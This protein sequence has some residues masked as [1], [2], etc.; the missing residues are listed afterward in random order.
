MKTIT[1]IP[2]LIAVTAYI[3]GTALSLHA[4]ASGNARKAASLPAT[5]ATAPIMVEVTNPA[6]ATIHVTYS[7]PEADVQ[8][9]GRQF[10]GTALSTIT[11]GNALQSSNEGEPV[12]PVVP[13]KIVLPAGCSIDAIKVTG[14]RKKTMEGTYRIRHGEAKIPL[15]PDAKPR[16]A[17][18]KSSIYDSDTPFPYNVVELVGVQKKRGV[19]IAILKI[20]PVQYRPRSGK[21]TVYESISFSLQTKKG[22]ANSRLKPRPNTFN[23]ASMH[24]EN[25][26]ALDTYGGEDESESSVPSDSGSVVPLGICDPAD[27]YR[28]VVVTA[29]SIRTATTDYTINDL[30]AHKQARGLTATIVTIEDVLANYTGTDNAERLRNF[31]IDAYTNWETDFVLLGG[32]IN[33]IPMRALHCTASSYTDEI[34]SD[35]YYQCLDGTYNSDGDSYWGEPTDGPGGTD[36]DLMAEVYIGRA[37]AENCLEMSNF[38]YKTLSYENASASAPYLRNALMVGEY[39]GFGGVADYATASM[40]EIRLGSSE[41]GYTTAGFA[42][43]PLFTVDT[44]YDRSGYEW[45]ASEIISRM[46]S[47]VYGIYNHLGHANAT[48]VMKFYNADADALTNDNFFF[49]Y[50]QGCIPGNFEV[51]CIAEHLTTSNRHGAFAVVFNARYGWGANSSTDGPSQRFDR[52]FWDAYFSEFMSNFGALNADSHE[53]NIWDINGDCIRWCFYETN[54]LGDPQTPVRG[55]V[56][57][58]SLAYHSHTLNDASGGNGDGLINPGETVALTLTAANLGTESATGVTA[59]ISTSDPYISVTGVTCIFGTIQCCGAT[60]VADGPVTLTVQSDCPTPHTATVSCE[61]RDSRD[62]TWTSTFTI[63]V[64]TSSQISG[65]VRTLTGGTPVAGATVSFTGPLS[66]S[67]TTDASGAYLFGGIDGTYTITVTADGYLASAP[68]SVTIPPAVSGIDFNLARPLIAVAPFSI[69]VDM[70][71]GEAETRTLTINNS[72]DATLSFSAAAQDLNATPVPLAESVYDASHF[73][74]LEKGAVDTRTGKP[75]ALGTGGPDAFG[76]RWEDSD[77]P[78]GPTYTWTDIS[79]TGTLLSSVS[80]CDDCYQSVSLSFPFELYGT[81]FSSLY[82]S[83]NG[84]IS[85]GSGS[86]QYSN[87]ALPSTSMPANLVA[88]FFD[89]LNPGSAGSIYFQDDGDRAVVQFTNVT[90]YGSSANLTYQMVLDRNGTITFYYNTMSGTLTSATV[91]IQNDTRDDG[92]SVVYNASYI[93]NGLAVRLR[94]APPWLSI[95]PESGTIAPGGSAE[96]DVHFS[97]DGMPAG[98][99]MG[100]LSLE[101]NDP[102][103]TSPLQVPCTLY[104]DGMR[105]LSV[106]PANVDFGPCWVGVRDTAVL[107]LTNAGDEPTVVSSVISTNGNF[108]S[109]ISPPLTVPAFGTATLEVEYA[110]STFGMHNG[111]VTVLSNAEDNPSIPVSVSGEGT[112]PPAI[113]VSPLSLSST[114]NAGDSSFHTVTIQNTG[115]AELAYSISIGYESS[116]LQH[117]NRVPSRIDKSTLI[118]SL[119]AVW[120]QNAAIGPEHSSQN[121]EKSCSELGTSTTTDQNESRISSILFHPDAANL[122]MP[123]ILCAGAPSTYDWFGD[124]GEKI[125]A[126]G[127]I[128]SVRYLD[129]SATTPTL[130]FLQSFDAVM[131]FNDASYQDAVLFGDNL[132]SYVDGGGSV[133]TAVFEVANNQLSGRWTNDYRAIVSTSQTSGTHLTL[134]EVLN[135]AH[136]IMNNVSQFDGGTS[137]YRANSITLMPGSEVVAN[138]S[139]GDPLIVTREIG[140]SKRV[141]LNFYPPS[142]D[143]RS[144]FW[145]ASTDGGQIMANAVIW[146]ITDGNWLSVDHS[147]GT[148]PA[149]ASVD[150][151][152]T[153]TTATLLGGNYSAAINI[154][155]NVPDS[156]DP[157]TIPVDMTVDGS[158]RLSVHPS[159]LD[160]GSLWVG[161]YDTLLCTLLNSGNEATQVSSISSSNPFFSP[162]VSLPLVVPAFDEIPVPVIFQ[163]GTIGSHSGALTILSNAEDNPLIT[164]A[165]NGTATSAPAAAVSPSSFSKVLPAGD[166]TTDD[167]LIENTGGAALAYTI[168]TNDRTAT[169]F[170]LMLVNGTTDTTDENGL[171]LPK[172]PVLIEGKLDVEYPFFDGFESGNWNNWSAQS[173]SYTREVT[174]A[175]S[176]SGRYSLTL[177]GGSYHYEGVRAQFTSEIQP[178][179]VSFSVRSFSSSNADGYFVLRT[180]GGSCP[181]FFFARGSGY[182]YAN[183]ETSYLYEADVWYDIRF[184]INWAETKFDFYINDVLVMAD[185]AFRDAVSGMSTVDLYNYDV[186]QAWWDNINI[187]GAP[188]TPWLT[189]TPTEGTV[190]PGETTVISTEFN[191]AGLLGGQYLSDITIATNSPGQSTVEVPCTLSVDGTRRLAASPSSLQFGSVWSGSTDTLSLRLLNNGNEATTVNS[192]TSDNPAFSIIGSTPLTVPPFDSIALPLLF[193][194]VTVGSHNGILTISSNAEDNPSISVS[195]A[196]EGTTPPVAEISPDELNYDLLPSS[197]PETRS[198]FVKNTGGDLLQYTVQGAYQI[199]G[200]GQ[201]STAAE[202]R[203]PEIRNDLIY[204]SGNT[205]NPFIPGRLIIGMRPAYTTPAQSL[206]DAI[207][208]AKIRTLGIARNPETGLPVNTQRKAYLVTLADTS[209]SGLFKA[210]DLL[211]NNPSVAYAEPDYIVQAIAVPDDPYF[212]QLY[213][214]HNTGQTGGTVDADIDATEVW[215]RHTGTRSILIGIIDTGIDYLHPDLAANI[216]TNPGEIPGNGIDDDGNGYIDDV[217]GWDFAY[218]DDDPIDGHYHGTHCAGTVA[219]AGDNGVGVAGVM[220]SASLVAL[221]F[222]DDGGSGA[223]SDAIDAVSYA[224]AMGISVTSNSWGG[225]A[226][227]QSLMDAIAL[228]GFFVAAAGNEGMNNDASPHYPSSYELDN[229]LAVAATDHNDQ[230][231]SFSCYGLT[232]VDLGAPGV[233]IYSCAPGGSYQSLSGTSM[234]TPHVSG[235]AGL[236]WSYNPSL[237]ALQVKEILMESVDPVASLSGITVTGGRLNVNEALDAAGPAW[238]SVSPVQSGEIEPGDSVELSVTV[239][240]AGLEGGTWTGEVVVTTD[241]PL[242]PQLAATVTAHIDGQRSLTVAPSSLD[243]SAIWIGLSDTLELT[244]TNSGN[245]ATEVLSITSDNAVFTPLV[246]W[247]LIVEPASSEQVPVVFS[248]VSVGEHT[249]TVTIVSNAEDNPSITINATGFGLTPPSI[250]TA[251]DQ[252]NVTMPPDQSAQR[253]LTIGNS[254]GDALD[255]SITVLGQGGNGDTIDILAWTPY[256]DMD[257]EWLNMQNGLSRYLTDYTVTTT[258]TFDTTILETALAS[259]EVFLIPEQE[260]S[261]IP[262]GTGTMFRG[263]LTRFLQQG[264]TIIYCCPGWQGNTTAFLLEAEL[265][266]LTSTGSSSSGTITITQPG[267]SLF[268]GISGTFSMVNATGHCQVNDASE[269]LATYSGYMVVA[270]K[271]LYSGQVITLGSDYYTD[272]NNWARVLCNAVLTA[273]P[274]A[275][276]L[277]LSSREGTVPPG[278]QHSVIA[279]LNTMDLELGTY[280]ST[281]SIVHNDP[282]HVSPVEIPVTL[283]VTNDT[284]ENYEGGI[285]S[286]G[287]SSVPVAQGTRFRIVDLTIGTPVAGKTQGSRFTAVLK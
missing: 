279:T 271:L 109:L 50:S 206:L 101:H 190:L 284:P 194:P 226:F 81:S 162:S 269:V 138:W 274:A 270:R 187:G 43:S 163:P 244:F 146:A 113:T 11:I 264:G 219:G 260:L 283:L 267:D 29:D 157:L 64:Y 233:D 44:L 123:D 255:Y 141:D 8:S 83:S 229:I 222:L 133:I 240:P 108:T 20:H 103:S 136:Y 135:P 211:R 174:E 78:G 107:T 84:Y 10:E 227:S 225:G 191:T 55:R 261:S 104:I 156:P 4:Q 69:R 272:D 154:S 76:Y 71:A 137:S 47:G 139:N 98:L 247:P 9:T 224:T 209:T 120:Q 27:S 116:P 276:W 149:G 112:T 202:S 58:P 178:E 19:A 236:V 167:L 121:P 48:Y 18:P 66:G 169:R 7:L 57:G 117:S 205:D 36:V 199:S 114:L 63:T 131:V 234:A 160:F 280:S 175:T 204:S 212:S 115:G 217:H 148:V 145:L 153:L 232:S 166:V 130:E 124:I 80:G 3:C 34:P 142:S 179:T 278:N 250:T 119:I 248:P 111:T 208:A 246:S 165:L 239:T 61:M 106:T 110:P 245:E 216:W 237:T 265:M 52:Q 189:V 215:D 134:G 213:G 33:I 286:I 180:S 210:I 214:M 73:V 70:L 144:D 14:G 277:T 28:Y 77:E 197:P 2:V 6:G 193:H 195:L 143:A 72:G 93:K 275:S 241:D 192:V 24:L 89:D 30:V 105:R 127:L 67:V 74:T 75:V 22:K 26:E 97:S 242:H 263:F 253:T 230:L 42:A 252:L 207:G 21:I 151:R 68:L 152:V 235:A 262:S 87:Y 125:I 102:T 94:A 126:S 16:K 25:P 228:S 140:N 49:A 249:G 221:K 173:G 168:T 218:D 54:L 161:T 170:P 150:I 185:V 164:V 171:L 82:V 13:A 188:A 196:G 282:L 65:H 287:T 238:L 32:D 45:P 182:F 51:D 256:T 99:S 35:L 176:A 17:K 12:L 177:T 88:G 31:I 231:A 158:N 268:T 159:S 259:K 258:A 96:C 60:D 122:D 220:W 198:V 92:L 203:L 91:G 5:P 86:S 40:E 147:S 201:P 37:S 59:T 95:N 39:L 266:E 62:S 128:R 200:P 184:E 172:K 285:L 56:T 38:V 53:D 90:Q 23:P 186:S 183:V 281:L 79:G 1:R 251:P 181:I 223:T 85:F 118:D 155:H 41:H 257:G 132:A 46:N 243:F 254:G 100:S 15:V 129:V 273:N